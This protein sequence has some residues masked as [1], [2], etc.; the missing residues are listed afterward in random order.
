MFTATKTASAR[1]AAIATNRR[2][3][4]SARQT[5]AVLAIPE[6][7]TDDIMGG[8]RGIFGAVIRNG[9]TFIAT[10]DLGGGFIAPPVVLDGAAAFVAW[11]FAAMTRR[12]A[13]VMISNW[14]NRYVG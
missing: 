6:G 3:L 10:V 2:V 13:T 14:E 9:S 7:V 5:A 8:A 11:M 1:R 12:D 4:P